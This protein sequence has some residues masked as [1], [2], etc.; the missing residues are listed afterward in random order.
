MSCTLSN[1]G[2]PHGLSSQTLGSGQEDL[3]PAAESTR[4]SLSPPRSA[5][6]GPGA[7]VLPA[8]GGH[9]C[10][11]QQETKH[12][13]LH[14]SLK[15]H[16]HLREANRTAWKPPGETSHLQSRDQSFLRSHRAAP[17]PGHLPRD[18]YPRQKAMWPGQFWAPAPEPA[19][20]ALRLWFSTLPPEGAPSQ[21]V[22]ECR[23]AGDLAKGVVLRT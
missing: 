12:P 6:A 3:P 5:P 11:R 17:G 7:A 13:I 8:A 1:L 9:P 19:S 23:P 22:S 16:L 2:L 10:P 4:P 20:R 14:G 15:A 18:N 21:H